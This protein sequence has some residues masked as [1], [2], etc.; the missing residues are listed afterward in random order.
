MNRTACMG[1][2]VTARTLVHR[3]FKFARDRWLASKWFR[4]TKIG[5]QRAHR[6]RREA[7]Q[8]GHTIV[9]KKFHMTVQ[10][11]L[12]QSKPAGPNARLELPSQAA[13]HP[14]QRPHLR[15]CNSDNCSHSRMARDTAR[16]TAQ[17]FAK[18]APP[19]RQSS[20]DTLLAHTPRPLPHSLDTKR[21]ALGTPANWR[22]ATGR[23]RASSYMYVILRPT[24]PQPELRA[25]LEARVHSATLA[26]LNT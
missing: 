21:S 4:S 14:P 23:G 6:D 1:C 16:D 15:R 26:R 3:Q 17:A 9:A 24:P 20:R 25:S 11:S 7:A 12:S 8:L 5:A 19:Q 22:S 10:Q 13:Q 18:P 2:M